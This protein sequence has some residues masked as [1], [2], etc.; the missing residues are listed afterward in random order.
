[1]QDIEKKASGDIKE[2]QNKELI[3]LLLYLEEN[4]IFYRD[5][6]VKNRINIHEIKSI[7]D[8]AKI[9]VTTKDDLQA[10]N[11]DFLCVEK[12][13]VVEYCCTSGTMGTPVTIA[14]TEKDMER[15]AYNE[16]LSFLCTGGSDS[17]IY[18]LML[19]LDRQF[20]AGIAYYAGARKLGAG[21]IRGGP[22]NFPMQLDTIERL[23]PNVLISVPSFIIQLINYANEKNVDL[24]ATSVKKIICIGEN[25]RNEDFSLNALGD[26]IV[27]NWKVELFSTYASTEQQTAFTE[28]SNGNGGH[29]HEEL[30]L[31]EILDENNNPLPSGEYGELAITTLGVQGMPLLRYKTGDICAYYDQPCSCGRTSSRISPVK[32]RKQQLI[33]YNGTTL[34]P[35]SV[36]NVLNQ[37][38]YIQDYVVSIYKND[39]GTDE[40]VINIAMPDSVKMHDNKIKQVLQSRLRV[41]PK[42]KY[43]ALAEIIS[44][45][46]SDG[47]RKASKLIDSR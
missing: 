33:K 32:G 34:Y 42:I 43:I 41:T 18:H 3:K 12:T 5:H 6:F 47:K 36:F 39:I 4:S 46:M 15:L 1:M 35:Q 21:I 13:K 23:S 2:Y 8:I 14:L 37:I 27:K 38:E 45:Q 11:W 31:F 19:S 30:M 7:H 20:M 24:N 40:M 17:D 28:C 9:P 44:M 26:R 10:R 25:I 22:G 29:H 16:Y